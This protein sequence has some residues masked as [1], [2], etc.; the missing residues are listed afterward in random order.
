MTA[1]SA[2]EAA[3]ATHVAGGMRGYTPAQLAVALLIG[4]FLVAFLVVPVATVIYVAFAE[5]GAGF[6][7]S[8]FE[9][10]FHLSLMRESFWNSL[11][12]AVLSVLFATL[13]AVPLAYFT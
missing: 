4:A 2:A 3:P 7:L 12:V 10:F 9:S 6:T 1:A 11:F 8:H 5:P 13:I